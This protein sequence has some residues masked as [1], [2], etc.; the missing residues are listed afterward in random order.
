MLEVFISKTGFGTT[1]DGE[2]VMLYTLRNKAGM[3]AKITNYGGIVVSLT[4]PDRDGNFED[5]VLGYDTL[6]EYE[7][8]NPYF[9]ALI[10]R[11]GNRIGKGQFEL[12]GQARQ[13]TTNDGPNQPNFP[14]TILR[15][16]E[17]YKTRTVYSFSTTD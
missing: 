8:L 2:K 11:Y 17:V 5:I 16:G 6:A 12:D 4:A 14:N 3:V 7:K 9:G 13:L 1:A 10:G 15:P